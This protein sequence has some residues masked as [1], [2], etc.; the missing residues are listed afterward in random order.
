M[1]SGNRAGEKSNGAAPR[2]TAEAIANAKAYAR[3]VNPTSITGAIR[4]AQ[5]VGDIA[6]ALTVAM[7]STL[8]AAL[9]SKNGRAVHR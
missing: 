3:R 7:R 1:N 5:N 2:L 6:T 4:K 9:L 8:T